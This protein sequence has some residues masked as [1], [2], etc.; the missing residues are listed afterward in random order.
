M[1]AL[2][3]SVR[4]IVLVVGLVVVW[5]A[6]GC[7]REKP[8]GEVYGKVT[9]NGK[10]VTAGMVKFFPEEGG[11]P[12]STSLGPDGTYR[13]TGVPVGRAKLAIETLA[14]KTLTPPPPG[15]AKQLGG[16]RTTYVPIPPK[17]EQPDTSGLA[18]DVERGT[19]PYDIV[20][21]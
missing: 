3:L 20:L 15:I 2:A 7:T 12:I 19:K 10:L 18:F 8:T 4:G 14:F 13:A 11:E 16:P 9:Y 5:S 21:D 6:P 1:R 17:Y